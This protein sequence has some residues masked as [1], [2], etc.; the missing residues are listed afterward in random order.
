MPNKSKSK[1]LFEF[2]NKFLSECKN[3]GIQNGKIIIAVSGGIDS[4]TLA[5]L[6]I[7]TKNILNLEL[8]IAHINHQ[9]RGSESNRDQNFVKNFAIKNK[10]S[11]DLLIANTNKIKKYEKRN[12]QDVARKIRYE[13]L[14][15]M[16]EK[17]NCNF[18]ST[19]HTMDDNAETILLNLFRGSGL[20]GL[21][22]IPQATTEGGIK[23]VRPLLSFKRS[24]IE[25]Y[26]KL[27][28][29]KW[30]EDSSNEKNK[31]S[32]NQ[33]RHL[34][35]PEIQKKYNPQIVETLHNTSQ[36]FNEYSNF[37]QKKVELFI[38]KN[39]KETNNTFE[40]NLSKLKNLE[41]IL[42]Q[43]VFKNILIKLS[44]EPTF[45]LIA[46]LS[47]LLHLQSGAKLDC[48]KK[49]IALIDHNLL[50]FTKRTLHPD[51]KFLLK[52]TGKVSFDGWEVSIE[53]TK[54]PKNFKQNKNQNVEFIDADKLKFPITIR[55]WQMGDSFF[56][57]GM[58]GKK[59]ISDYFTDQKI[60]FLTKSN[61]PILESTKK[62][63]WVAG[64]RL[65]ER[66]KITNKTKN[67]YKLI[68]KYSVNKS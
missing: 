28:K 6:F 38:S 4:I 13:Y 51:F 23:I 55:N 5:N 22:G 24:E 50:I 64:F 61:T 65:D 59:K 43:S 35:I 7:E 39:I 15:N 60:P 8:R 17:Q 47:N 54:L 30:V 52:N 44:I 53:K 57:L 66:F 27:K 68:I 31:Y 46:A 67:I 21:S 32:R 63:I 48:N 49:W 58:Y 3:I 62:I 16:T 45:K 56:P 42:Q 10:L 26:S 36:I 37:L 20:K 40:V 34:L 29:L 9:L 11:F 25:K 18:I 1:F 2:Q 12:I 41:N 19:A 33:I 14:R